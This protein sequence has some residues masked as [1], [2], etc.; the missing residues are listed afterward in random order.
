MSCEFK[1]TIKV[2]RK[3]TLCFSQ[4]FKIYVTMCL[5]RPKWN[6]YFVQMNS[7][8]EF[9]IQPDILPSVFDK[10]RYH[11]RIVSFLCKS[12]CNINY[13][14]CFISFSDEGSF[15]IKFKD[16]IIGNERFHDVPKSMN[17]KWL[18]H[19]TSGVNG[20]T[21]LAE[22]GFYITDI[23]FSQLQT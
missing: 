10:Q 23:S 22:I 8:K 3:Q 21:S 12:L 17:N 15:K 1:N 2:K 20:Y 5:F 14:V 9:V 19:L 13:L 6:F 16:A 7:V 11:W 4:V 18:D